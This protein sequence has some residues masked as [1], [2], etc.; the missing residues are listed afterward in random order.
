[1]IKKILLVDDSPVARKMLKRVIPKDKGYEIMEAV[2]GQDGIE[3]YQTF[4]PDVT[5]LD[6]TMPV[7]DGFQALDQIKQLNKS[8]IVIIITADIQQKSIA[9]VMQSGAFTLLKKPVSAE[10]LEETL[11]KAAMNVKN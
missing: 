11:D 7:L 1:M 3:K 4:Q 5:L 8:A 9:T 6:L 10:I 2:D